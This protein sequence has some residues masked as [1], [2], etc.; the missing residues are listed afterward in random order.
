MKAKVN[1]DTCIGCGLCVEYCPEVFALDDNNI[2]KPIIERIPAEIR[3]KSQMAKDN[4]P[5]DAISFSD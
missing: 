3:E 1:P 4:C 2:A 5:V